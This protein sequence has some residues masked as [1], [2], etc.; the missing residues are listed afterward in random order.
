MAEWNRAIMEDERAVSGL[1]VG[2][3]R[4]AAVDVGTATRERS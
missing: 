3:K 1:K 4:S 2:T